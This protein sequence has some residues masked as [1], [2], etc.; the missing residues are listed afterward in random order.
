[1]KLTWTG[2][3][4]WAVDNL[5]YNWFKS[6]NTNNTRAHWNRATKASSQH[7]G[8]GQPRTVALI[9]SPRIAWN[10]QDHG[11]S[12]AYLYGQWVDQFPDV[13]KR[14][15]ENEPDGKGGGCVP[16]LPP[17]NGSLAIQVS[18]PETSYTLC[19][20]V[21]IRVIGVCDASENSTSVTT[22]E[23]FRSYWKKEKYLSNDRQGVASPLEGRKQESRLVW[24]IAVRTLF[25][26][27]PGDYT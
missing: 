19:A 27:I 16:C 4:I 22:D 13:G 23:R 26:Y 6:W 1:M 12:C 3:C 11:W 20:L 15:T 24:N 25:W 2:F 21:R 17:F 9:K 5:F 18:S 7:I 10:W 8:V 14:A